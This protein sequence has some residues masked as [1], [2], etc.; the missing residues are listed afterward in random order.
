MREEFDLYYSHSCRI[1]LLGRLGFEYKEPKAIPRVANAEKQAAFVQ[2]EQLLNDLGV[3][4]AVYFC[5]AVHPE[6]QTKPAHRWV[7]RGASVAV[8]GACEY[9]RRP[10]P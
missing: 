7:R 2:Y 5:D 9:S 10:E 1:K 8:G 4:K 6:H 3:D